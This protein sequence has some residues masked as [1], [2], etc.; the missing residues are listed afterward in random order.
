MYKERFLS[1]DQEKDLP[2]KVAL[3]LFMYSL[4]EFMHSLL[5]EHQFMTIIKVSLH[6]IIESFNTFVAIV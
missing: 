1:Y 2:K 5:K 3:V 6:S 4:Y